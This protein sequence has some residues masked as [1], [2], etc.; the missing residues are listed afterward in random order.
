MVTQRVGSHLIQVK[1]FCTWRVL[2][3]ASASQLVTYF[4]YFVR[5][6]W[7]AKWPPPT[8]P[9][10]FIKTGKLLLRLSNH[11]SWVSSSRH[12]SLMLWKRKFCHIRLED[13]PC[14][15]FY[16]YGDLSR[17]NSCSGGGFWL[18]YRRASSISA[19]ESLTAGLFQGFLADF[20]ESAIFFSGF[21]TI[22]CRERA[23]CWTFRWGELEWNMGL[24]QL[25]LGN[26]S[27]LESWPK[28]T[29]LGQSDRRGWTRF[30]QRHPA[31][32]V[33]IGLASAAVKSWKLLRSIL[34]DVAGGDTK[35]RF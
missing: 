3:L 20:A 12:P 1:S 19:A 21:V 23:G 24:F 15:R 29:W 6:D 30:T 25:M 14:Q 28:A 10:I 35:N 16:G 31:G 18:C 22:A 2:R 8:A 17:V 26:G 7:S 13:Q 33:F 34:L 5:D 27:R 32:T 9:Y 4:H 11:K